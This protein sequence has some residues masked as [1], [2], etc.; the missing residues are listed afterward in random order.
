MI[1]IYFATLFAVCCLIIYIIY[2]SL[3]EPLFLRNQQLFEM[4]NKISGRDYKF[5]EQLLIVFF[6]LAGKTDVLLLRN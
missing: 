5:F 2:F 6:V 1:Y 3:T 4:E